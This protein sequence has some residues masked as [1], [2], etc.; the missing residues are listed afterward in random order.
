MASASGPPSARNRPAMHRAGLAG[1]GWM[2]YIAPRIA[3]ASAPTRGSATPR[4]YRREH[5][6]DVTRVVEGDNISLL[7]YR[8]ELE[9]GPPPPMAAPVAGAH[10]PAPAAPVVS[11]P[12][13]CLR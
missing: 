13:R 7:H 2:G 9:G 4:K 1:P 11:D 12:S 8:P 3:M 6:S 5:R 10:V